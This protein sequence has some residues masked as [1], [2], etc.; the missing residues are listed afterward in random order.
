MTET[1]YVVY[2]E[3]IETTGCT[4]I[5]GRLNENDIEANGLE[6][7]YAILYNIADARRI[8]FFENAKDEISPKD[9]ERVA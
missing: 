4:E 2:V 6:D 7:D 3:V 9:Y 1:L 8:I 5:I